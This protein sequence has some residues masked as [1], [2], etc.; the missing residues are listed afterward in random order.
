MGNKRNFDEHLAERIASDYRKTG[1]IREAARRN[2]VGDQVARKLLI[3][4]GAYSTPVIDR[5]RE[6][7]SEGM[8]LEEI[9]EVVGIS[10]SA[11]NSNLPYEKGNYNFEQTVNA[12]RIKQSRSKQ[13]TKKDP[14]N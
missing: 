3:T 14:S 2:K 8:S 9:A 10:H 5:I 11:V 4:I 1:N 13:Q 7:R 12:Q 6:L